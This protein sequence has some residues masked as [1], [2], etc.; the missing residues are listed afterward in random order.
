V[1][2]RAYVRKLKLGSQKEWEALGKAG[3]RPSNIP[4]SP[5]PVYRDDGWIS[6]PDWLGYKGVVPGKMLPFLVARAIVRKLKLKSQEEW[7]AW[8]KSGQRPSNIPSAPFKTYRD[9]GWISTS[10]WLGYGSSGGGQAASQSS[11]SGSAGTAAKKNK[12]RSN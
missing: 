7:Q 3:E 1:A 9:D 4:C 6:Y 5:Y 8:R 11:S 12:T 2:A 10:D